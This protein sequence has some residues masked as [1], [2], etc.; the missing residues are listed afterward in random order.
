MPNTKKLLTIVL[1]TYNRCEIVK[2]SVERLLPQVEKLKDYV[3]LFIT[4]NCSPDD[5]EVVV[6]KLIA[7]SG[8]YVVYNR[9]KENIGAQGNF[10]LGVHQAQTKYVY[11][12][13]DD[14]VIPDGFLSTV[15]SVLRDNTSIDVLHINYSICHPR[16]RTLSS[17][18][19]DRKY[20]NLVDIYSSPVEFISEFLDGPSFMSSII[21]NKDVWIEG[22]N[23]FPQDCYGYQWLMKIYAGCANRIL[24]FYSLPLLIQEYGKVCAYADKCPLYMIA[25]KTK[26]FTYLDTIL[27]GVLIAWK[28]KQK[29]DVNTYINIVTTAAYKP[30]YREYKK[31]MLR[32]LN[33]WYQR[34]LFRLSITIFPSGKLM[35]GFVGPSFR[36]VEMLLKTIKKMFE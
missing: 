13:G 36:R 10:S 19:D 26:L 5:T 25:G 28:K 8:D 24:A 7:N 31:E 23:K 32:C 20:R 16:K 33:T 11:M 35:P 12:L 34:L 18:Y 15:V 29:R 17:I 1:P 3:T 14:D 9:N 6:K 2:Q 21:F 22:E 30:L 27:P 4:D